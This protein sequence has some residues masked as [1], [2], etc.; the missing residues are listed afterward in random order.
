L[1]FGEQLEEFLRHLRKERGLT[2]AS[3]T[4]RRRCLAQF[5][6]WL[7]ARG[8]SIETIGPR[9]ITEYFSAHGVRSWKRATV[10]S[11]ADSLRSFLR[12][13]GARSWCVPGI[14]AAVEGPRIYS[15]EALPQGP[16]WKD[17]QRLIASLRGDHPTQI[18]NRAVVLLLAVYSF[19]IGEVCKLTLDDICWE[20]ELIHVR[21]SKQRRVQDY[22]LTVEVGTA[23]LKYLERVRP[24][25]RHRELF[26][27]L[28]TPF[29][30]ILPASL[31]ARIALLMRHLNLQLP[32]YG[33]HTL[34]H[35][36][37]T[38]L[39]SRGFSLKEIGDHLG[40]RSAQATQVYAKVDVPSLRKV[41]DNSLTALI[42][43]PLP[44]TESAPPTACDDQVERL[45]QVATLNLGGVL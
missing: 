23:I 9:E 2:D 6:L 5:F 21:R 27:T 18:R 36:C 10:K 31:G 1:P 28:R 39:L 17:V 42:N 20:T 45:R 16:T 8:G 37:A 12:Y 24:K 30:P 25:S 15:F 22:P 4:H 7:S 11:Y 14:D 13:A 41:G 29:R 34:R 26:L 35:A 44:L 19:R 43:Y 32:H 38:H 40:H 3:V 33:P